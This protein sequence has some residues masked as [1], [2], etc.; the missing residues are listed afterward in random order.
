MGLAYAYLMLGKYD[1]ADAQLRQSLDRAA[2][3]GDTF[4]T[5]FTHRLLAQA[6]WRRG[7][8]HEALRHAQDM[9][10]MLRAAETGRPAWLAIAL[11]AV[12]WYEALLGDY[13]A[14]IAHC[15]EALAVY[16]RTG[17]T[18]GQA[19]VLDSL[20]YAYHHR[21]EHGH[22]VDRYHQA[23][24]LFRDIGDRY[25]E[26]D[27]LTRLGDAHHATGDHLR[28]GA[29]WRA[30]LDILT[31]LDHPNVVEV[32]AK[33]DRLARERPPASR[34]LVPAVHRMPHL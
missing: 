7:D 16:Q 22:A 25:N 27:T 3:G 34:Y 4:T 9:L 14:A 17:S 24:A 18:F 28:A 2:E 30:A 20:G 31:E 5:A 15:T 10:A 33:L 13:P 19:K 8:L 32:R 23:I 1:E 29:S 26:A 12:G 11:N 6:Q 21:G